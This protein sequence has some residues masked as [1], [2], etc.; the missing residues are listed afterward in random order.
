M[1]GPER[2]NSLTIVLVTLALFA[3]ASPFTDWWASRQPPWYFPYVLW[4]ILIALT[5]LIER[6]LRRNEH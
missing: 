1:S 3:F 5:F 4:A 6:W 2:T